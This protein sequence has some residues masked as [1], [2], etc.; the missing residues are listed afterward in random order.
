MT[1]TLPASRDGGAVLAPRGF[2]RQA[3][4]GNA[5]TQAA[6]CGYLFPRLTMKRF[7]IICC[8][9]AAWSLRAATIETWYSD[10]HTAPTG[11]P[12]LVGTSVAA[13]KTAKAHGSFWGPFADLPLRAGDSVTL[14]CTWKCDV[15]PGERSASQLRVALLGAPRASANYRRDLRGF[16]LTGGLT[17]GKWDTMLWERVGD[18]PSP[19]VMANTVVVAKF[20]GPEK[21][22]PQQTMRIVLTVKKTAD[23][24]FDVSGFWGAHAFTFPGVQCSN[25]LPVLNCVGFLN[26]KTSGFD[27]MTIENCRV[28]S[29]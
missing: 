27:V 24:T 20:T 8:A 2:P 3:R 12:L 21:S 6:S 10:H 14:N 18:T 1:A 28:V 19:C 26:G 25:D 13:D 11:T 16:V 9:L 22:E 17:G 4:M 23:R 7:A 29:P 15:P 5:V